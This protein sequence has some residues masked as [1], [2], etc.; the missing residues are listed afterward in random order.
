MAATNLQQRCPT[1]NFVERDHNRDMAFFFKLISKESFNKSYSLNYCIVFE[2]I[3]YNTV[4]NAPVA[5]KGRFG[6]IITKEHQYDLRIIS[7]TLKTLQLRQKKIL[8]QNKVSY[9]IQ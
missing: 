5:Y 8:T 1:N 9:K 6:D 3:L 2:P 7:F 4:Y